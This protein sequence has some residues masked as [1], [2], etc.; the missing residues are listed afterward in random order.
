MQLANV[1][2][3]YHPRRLAIDAVLWTG[4][5]VTVIATGALAARSLF[6]L[7]DAREAATHVQTVDKALKDI[8]TQLLNAE[9]GQ[10]G[11]LLS[12]KNV[13]LRSY[14]TGVLQL[15]E[16]RAALAAA[17]GRDPATQREL[18]TLDH[19]IEAK[20]QELDQTINQKADDRDG[21]S[22][23]IAID[24]GAI[25]MSSARD[26]LAKLAAAESR[27]YDVDK[28]GSEG[29]LRGN[30][31]LLATALTLSS[32][33]L[34][35]L[36]W[37][38]R[39]LAS[40]AVARNVELLRLLEISAV[41]TEHVRTLSALNRFLHSC[42]DLDEAQLLLC[43]QLGP[44]MKAQ[45]GAFYTLD[46][47]HNHLRHAFT[48]GTSPFVTSFT[49]SECWALRLNQPYYQPADVGAAACAHLH[50]AR[51]SEHGSLQCWPLGAQGELLGLMVLSIEIENTEAA[52]LTAVEH[53]GYRREVLEQVAL[54]LGNLK[55]REMLRQQS[56]RDVLTGLYNRRFL[57]ESL[58][59]ALECVA[60]EHE[61][62]EYQGLALLMIDIDHFKRFNDE[63]GHEFGDF[64][65]REVAQELKRAT[66]TSDVAARYGGEEFTIVMV[67][68][69]VVKAAA[70]AEELRAAIAGLA[71][72]AAGREIGPV[73]IS[74][75]MAI[76]PAHG[77]SS[78]AL[79]NVADKALY[80]AKSAGRNQVV[81]GRGDWPTN[82]PERLASVG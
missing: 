75:G 43:D 53:E 66:R 12:G 33:L 3:I 67:D 49:P 36:V 51:V 81:V 68:I 8:L 22:A 41:R 11:F 37:R 54:A 1:L 17:L 28:S 9:S 23:G 48:W 40:R 35:A 39:R 7:S 59:Q 32:V 20:L 5:V 52:R 26:D 61:H 73:T 19:D 64:I 27:R 57:E 25:S 79:M 74:I 15:R 69:T 13:Y 71:L 56:I 14:Y 63:Y 65:L 70:R 50:L 80:A 34:I 82:P 45:H 4:L 29:E 30:Y 10:R 42:V 44:L 60:R 46:P 21:S 6:H 47:S 72:T 18:A 55:L 76:C 78:E 77:T 24:S 62:G 58:K 38:S 2:P 31:W 16:S